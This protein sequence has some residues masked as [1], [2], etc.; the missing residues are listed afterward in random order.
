[1]LAALLGAFPL[2]A[3]AQQGGGQATEPGQIQK[4]IRPPEAP[5]GPDQEI[6]LPKPAPRPA[7]EEPARKFVLVGVE[8]AGSTVYQPVALSF[9]YESLLS[10]EISLSD[11]E[12]IL[13]RITQKYRGDG[14]ILSRAIAPPQSI[15]VGILRIQ[16]IEGFVERVEY[17]GAKPGGERL[18]R[19]FAD[20]IKAARPLS[21]AALER[22]LL[23]MADAPGLRVTPALKALDEA[24]G[25]YLLQIAL[26]HDPVDGFVNLNNRGTTPVGPLQAL[27]GVNLNS[28]LGMLE[29]TRLVAFT[30]PNAPEELRYGQIY[31][32]QIVNSEGTRAWFAASRSMVDTG[33]VGDTEQSKQNSFGTRVTLGVSHP[34]IRSRATNLTARLRFD[35][36]DSDK[37]SANP[38]NDFDERLRVVRLG[39]RLGFK[40]GIGGSNSINVEISKGLEVL[41]ATDR[42]A[43]LTSRTNGRADFVKLKLDVVRRQKL[44][45]NLSLQFTAS[46]QK[47]PHT[48]LSSEEFSV[49]GR[50]FGRAYDPSEISGNEGAAG[51]L[52]LRF[53]SPYK[54][55]PMRRIQIYGYYDFGAV[56]GAGFTRNSMASAGG[57]LRLGLPFDINANIEFA[58]PLTR[59][60]TPGESDQRSPRVFFNILARF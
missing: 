12:K 23:L 16:V 19:G 54:P 45:K 4:R 48:L 27:A 40:D 41:H 33:I 30:V 59:A 52:E 55:A 29:R 6:T 49:G 7:V 5:R 36:L 26:R 22:Y 18:L 43:T 53:D 35:A 46:A 1:M 2:P 44:V 57:G 60:I 56:W 34:F 28:A 17:T 8:I 38:S 58:W 9:A 31:H 21:L 50:R 24:R 11:V 47:S 39:G 20:R 37:N 25:A 3:A 32:E 42:N 10:R 15:E 51:A 14:Y 13:D